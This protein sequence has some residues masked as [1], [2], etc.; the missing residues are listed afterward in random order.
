MNDELI[1]EAKQRYPIGTKIKSPQSGHNFIIDT[2][3]FFIAHNNNDI[4]CVTK[5]FNPCIQD[6][7]YNGKWSEIISKPEPIIIN[8]YDIW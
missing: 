4:R 6:I 7:R 1:A 2:D 8:T 5:K 3:E